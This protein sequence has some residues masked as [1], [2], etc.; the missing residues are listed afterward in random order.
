ML[1]FGR[2]T[3]RLL[4]I[5]YQGADFSARRRVAFDALAPGPGEV[6]V[7]IGCGNG[8]LSADLARAVGA[9]G[10]LIGIDPS[11]EMRAAAAERCADCGWARIDEGTAGQLPLDAQSID[12]A[13]SVQVFEYLDDIPAALHE[14]HRVLKPG[15][16]LV[17]GDIHFDS[18]IWFSDDPARMRR[19]MSVWD[20][21]LAEPAVPALLP[22]MLK[23]AGFSLL[24]I[25]PMTICDHQ[26]RPD[27]LA[28]M[29]SRLMPRYAVANGLIPTAEAEAWGAE[30]TALAAAGR[31]FFSVTHFVLSAQRR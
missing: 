2:E 12:K 17:I 14:A 5:A 15:G 11:R 9:R 30:Q 29:L 23:E 16:R 25:V 19:M 7:D 1:S 8:W 27:G 4:E 10:R 6:I 21:H 18:W 31:F 24:Q 28:M 3:T 20:D 22:A 13:V 26:L